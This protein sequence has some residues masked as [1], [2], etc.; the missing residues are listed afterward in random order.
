MKLF[1]STAEIAAYMEELR[2]KEFRDEDEDMALKEW[3]S[4]RP[5]EDR[6]EILANLTDEEQINLLDHLYNKYFSVTCRRVVMGRYVS[7]L[8]HDLGV[9]R[10]ETECLKNKLKVVTAKKVFDGMDKKEREEIKKE[11]AYICQQK[12]IE[13]FKERARKFK[14]EAEMWATR[15]NKLEMEKLEGMFNF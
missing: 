8:K 10:M 6:L 15:A 12:E 5:P 4:Y 3:D 13:Y 7:K 1:N 11:S 9:E 2:A 14:N